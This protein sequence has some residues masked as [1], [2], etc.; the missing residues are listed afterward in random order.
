MRTRNPN[1]R[2]RRVVKKEYAAVKIMGAKG[3]LQYASQI[4]KQQK[5]AETYK[6]PDSSFWA[7]WTPI[8]RLGI[9]ANTHCGSYTHNGITRYM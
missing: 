7:D 6:N 1:K 3:K 2:Q 8:R 9:Y 5:R 4:K